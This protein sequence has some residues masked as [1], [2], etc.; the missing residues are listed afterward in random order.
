MVCYFNEVLNKI[1]STSENKDMTCQKA[2][3]KPSNM[4]EL[5]EL[6][7]TVQGCIFLFPSDLDEMGWLE[8]VYQP[9]NAVTII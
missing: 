7:D 3:D 4:P 2:L 1:V 5:T 6:Q 9:L 8:A